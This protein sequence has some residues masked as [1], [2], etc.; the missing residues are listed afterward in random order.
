[1]RIKHSRD[2]N[3][4]LAGYMLFVPRSGKQR[5][6]LS[7]S[8]L[9]EEEVRGEGEGG[10]AGGGSRARQRGVCRHRCRTA[11]NIQQGA[12]VCVFPC[13]CGSRVWGR[14]R[15]SGAKL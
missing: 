9:G 5:L 3:S 2:A 13:V 10:G 4:T 7:L 8:L 15:R 11:N 14:G 1:M 12:S 6:S